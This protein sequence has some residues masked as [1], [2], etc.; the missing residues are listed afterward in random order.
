MYTMPHGRISLAVLLITGLLSVHSAVWAADAVSESVSASLSATPVPAE[1]T[2]IEDD[3]CL[4]CHDTFAIDHYKASVH[5]KNRCVACHTDIKEVPHEEKLKP[6]DCGSCHAIE[7]R[8]YNASDHGQA[9]QHGV[10]AANCQACHGDPHAVMDLHAPNSP[11]NRVNI[12]Q[13]CAVCH[14]DQKK[15][16]EFHLLV[17]R[18]LVTYEETIHGQAFKK[19]N[20]SA[21][22]CTDCHGSHDLH[23]P[24]NPESKIYWNKIPETCGKCHENVRNTYMQSIHGKSAARGKREAP[25]C[26]DCHGEHTIK[27][28]FDPASSVYAA[29]LSEKTCG[30]CHA[31]EKIVSKY[32]LP[33]DRLQ[34]YEESYHGL[35]SKLGVT[36]VANCASCHGAHDV[37]PSSDPASS[38]NKNNLPQTCGK[39]HPNVGEQLAKGDVHLAPSAYKDQAVYFVTAFYI[40][41]IILVI[42][43][44]LFHNF[45]DFR[46]K[47]KEHYERSKAVSN[48]LRFTK[49][50]RIQHWLL[51][52]SFTVLAYSGFA[53]VFPE[54]WWAKPFTLFELPFD[55]R[56]TVHRSAAVIFS[57]LS[58]YHV[59]YAAFTVRGREQIKALWVCKKDFSDVIQ[60]TLF[61]LGKTKVKP[62]L[63][64]FAYIEKAE[65]WA[66]IW[67][68]LIM[69]VTGGMLTFEDI[70]MRIFPK[71]FLDVATAIHLYEATLATLAII[72]WHFYFVIFDP[73]HYPMNWSMHTGRAKESH[74][75]DQPEEKT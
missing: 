63:G 71:W 12:A 53:L 22:T 7:A 34:T 65:Y 11:V 52:G 30:H 47:V 32:R 38:V 73:E 15:M 74:D 42:G 8:I 33:S 70:A 54:S 14:E 44:M 24:S 72:V 28:R 55:L 37:L 75:Q 50:E 66:L 43:G 19:G 57:A 21:A 27:S 59:I 45:L 36:T 41:L 60:M 10:Q 3:D 61:N 1:P 49:A 58:V 46:R 29:T 2:V 18:P 67:G 16:E 62:K 25:V 5:G 40:G 48:T 26:T 20:I 51:F 9:R 4:A 64:H 39:C 23:A 31:A 35:A 69:I 17:A 6:V 68:S 56:G 13:T